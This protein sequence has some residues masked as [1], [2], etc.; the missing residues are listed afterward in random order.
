MDEQAGEQRRY[1]VLF[2]Q[3]QAGLVKGYAQMSYADYCSHRPEEAT[4]RR[5]GW[6]GVAG[7]DCD[8]EAMEVARIASEQEEQEGDE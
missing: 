6:I 8:C 4:C 5:C 3:R 7:E 1:L 2:D